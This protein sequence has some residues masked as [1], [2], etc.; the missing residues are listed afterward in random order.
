MT[1][2][3]TIVKA[4]GTEEPFDP[5]KLARSLQN[6]GASNERRDKIVS[7]IQTEIFDGM[8]TQAIYRHA[9][10]LLRRE[11]KMPV[12]ARYS[13]KRAVFDLG[14]S[15]FPFERFIAEVLRTR[16]WKTRTG[17]MMNGKCT[18]H[19]VDVFG[20][21]EGERI[22]VEAKFHNANGT[23][24]DV[25]EAL[26]VHARFEDLKQAPD[27]EHRV[28]AGW[29]V[30]NTQF[31]R[32]A[33]RYGQCV[34]LTMIGWNHPRDH[35]LLMMIEHGQV[36]PITALTTL[37]DSEKQRLLDNNIVLCRTV[38]HAKHLLEDHGVRPGRIEEAMREARELCRRER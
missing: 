20:E 26:Y 5:K 12:A 6:A 31:T 30:T 2:M 29:L 1:S 9:F 36:H 24:S 33:F 18:S 16:G 17:V 37:N 25:K 35:G 22:G 15:G 28:D 4:D 11:E 19:E 10:E 14:P 8:T 3:P 23:K 21:R 27:E 13:M 38:Q 34:G 32:N 7:H